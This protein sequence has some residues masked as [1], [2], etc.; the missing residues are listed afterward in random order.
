MEEVDA[1]KEDDEEADED[2]LDNDGVFPKVDNDFLGSD[3]D[4]VE[5]DEEEEGDEDEDSE[6]DDDIGE[7][8]NSNYQTSIIVTYLTF[9]SV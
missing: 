9:L 1:D 4:E 7:V 5:E 3:E 2:E 6:E 8:F